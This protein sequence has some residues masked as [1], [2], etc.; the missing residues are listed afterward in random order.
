MPYAKYNFTDAVNTSKYSREETESIW[1]MPE[2][3][4]QGMKRVEKGK[5]LRTDMSS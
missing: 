5:E 4:K 2:W 3:L 1:Y